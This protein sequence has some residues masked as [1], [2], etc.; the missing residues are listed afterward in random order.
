M[1]QPV[2]RILIG[3]G[4]GALLGAILQAAEFLLGLW[5]HPWSV[6]A[7]FHVHQSAFGLIIVLLGGIFAMLKHRNQGA[8]WIGI[9][10]G[11]IAIHTLLDG[12]LIFIEH[13][14]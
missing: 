6:A 2:K 5:D 10:I 14:R 11:I 3:T 9:G 13:M 4:T 7:G 12:R 1:T 8:L